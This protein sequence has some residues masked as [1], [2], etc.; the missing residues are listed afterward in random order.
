MRYLGIDFGTK[1]VGLALSDEAGKFAFP[2]QILQNNKKLVEDIAALIKDENVGA[3]VVGE[4][5][6][7]QG[8][9][10]LVMKKTHRF[11]EELKKN[12]DKEIHFHPEYLS[13]AEAGRIIQN[14]EDDAR[15]AAIILQSFIDKNK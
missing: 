9:E 7:F 8:E 3:I 10:N 12:T 13:S 11:I 14:K 1:K 4:S 15:A 2:K 5:K 6:N